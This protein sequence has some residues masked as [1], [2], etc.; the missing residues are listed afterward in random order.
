MPTVQCQR[1]NCT[2]GASGSNAAIAGACIG[3][4]AAGR[5][6][7]AW[8]VSLLA[9]QSCGT[10]RRRQRHFGRADRWTPDWCTDWRVA[11]GRARPGAEQRTEI[12]VHGN[13]GHFGWPRAS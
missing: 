10:V 2:I 4:A 8:P 6:S 1:S 11:R 9:R 7:I 13:Y 12:R 5:W 3:C